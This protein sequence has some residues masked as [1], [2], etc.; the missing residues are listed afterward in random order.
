MVARVGA[1]RPP[2]DVQVEPLGSVV[3]IGVDEE[4]LI[5]WIDTK[6]DEFRR[7]VEGRRGA[8]SSIY[9][10]PGTLERRSRE[11]FREE[12]DAWQAAARERPTTG[13][14]DL[15][16]RL[17]PGVRVRITNRTR[18]FLR[19]VR[20]DIKIHGDVLAV[21]WLEE[22]RDAGI[23]LFPE[24]PLPWGKATISHLLPD[25]RTP[26]LPSFAPPNPHGIVQIKQETPAALCMSMTSLRPEEVHTSDADEF[27]LLMVLHDDEA[28]E[29]VTGGWR[30]T[31]EDVDGVLEGDF[32]VPVDYRNWREPIRQLLQGNGTN[33]VDGDAEE[34]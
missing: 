32:S 21:D 34:A 26:H 15:A 31:A 27:V 10:L 25:I 9:S 16:A 28:P 4:V 6:A 22:D 5:E 20:V 1:K 3:A 13:V 18:T 33:E 19:D 7:Q 23:D 24:L 2:V 12:V 17:L 29:A 30:V 8:Q 11:E 14:V